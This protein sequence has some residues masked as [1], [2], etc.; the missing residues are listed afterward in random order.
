MKKVFA[1]AIATF[2]LSTTI[3]AQVKR[4]VE[5]TQKMQKDKSHSKMK[6]DY[7]QLNLNKEQNEKMKEV[8]QA[9][10]QQK[11]AIKNDQSLS[12]EQKV[13]K[14]KELRHSQKQKVNSILTPAQKAQQKENIEKRKE[15]KSDKDH[16]NKDLKGRD[17]KKGKGHFDKK[18]RNQLAALDLSQTQ[19]DELKNYKVDSKQRKMAIKNDAS[20]TPEQKESKLKVLKTEAHAN[21]QKILTPEQRAKLKANRD[22]EKNHK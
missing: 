15:Y 10:K 21:M 3:N 12:Q 2:L 8:F 6:N 5:P 19:K 18:N 22:K 14:M 9:S 20:L 16:S 17:H 11:D 13:V 4:I 1:I 7:S